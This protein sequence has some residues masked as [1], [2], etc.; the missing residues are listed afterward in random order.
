MKHKLMN[1]SCCVAHFDKNGNI[2]PACIKCET[3]MEFI[4][5]DKLNSE[6]DKKDLQSP[7]R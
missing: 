4:P 6:C 5:Y 7:V 3:C 1:L 2:L